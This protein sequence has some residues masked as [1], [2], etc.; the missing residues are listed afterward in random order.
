MFLEG[1]RSHNRN[2]LPLFSVHP[3]HNHI[4]NV[5][6]VGTEDNDVERMLLDFI[7]RCLGHR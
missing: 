7:E 6:S 3:N 5:F 4:S 2:A 1:Y